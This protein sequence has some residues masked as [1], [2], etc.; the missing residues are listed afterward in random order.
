METSPRRDP[1]RDRLGRGAKSACRSLRGMS[2]RVVIHRRGIGEVIQ[3]RATTGRP[4][5]VEDGRL[6]TKAHTADRLRATAAD[7]TAVQCLPQRRRMI[8]VRRDAPP[9]HTAAVRTVGRRR[10][11]TIAVRMH[12]PHLP[13]AVAHTVVRRLLM[14]EALM[15]ARPHPMAVEAGVEPRPMA[16]AALMV[17]ADPRV[18]PPAADTL[19]PP[20]RAP[21]AVVEAART[22]AA[23]PTAAI[24]N[25]IFMPARHAVFGRRFFTSVALISRRREV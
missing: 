20:A 7:R 17:A 23:T 16:E 8:A 9:L 25:V 12:A 5:V 11:H 1:M 2:H 19:Q 14:A 22:A 21:G 6:P 10:L 15:A 3:A 18:D 13:T 24:T 4:T